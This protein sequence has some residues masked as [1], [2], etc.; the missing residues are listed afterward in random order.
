M[1]LFGRDSM[2]LI[3]ATAPVVASL[4]L[5]QAGPLVRGSARGWD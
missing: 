3:T 5:R 2:I 1:E 4:A